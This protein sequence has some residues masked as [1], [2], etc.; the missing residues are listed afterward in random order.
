MKYA[1]TIYRFDENDDQVELVDRYITADQAIDL[2]MQANNLPD[3]DEELEVAETSPDD[4][5]ETDDVEAEQPKTK[6]TSNGAGGN[7]GTKP[8]RI[9]AAL[10][11]KIVADIEADELAPKEIAEKHGVNLQ[12]I[13]NLRSRNAR[14]E[15]NESDEPMQ[16]PKEP[17]LT[18]YAQQIRQPKAPEKTTEEKITDMVKEG[19]SLSELE[20][21][22]PSVPYIKLTEIYNQFKD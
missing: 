8:R 2:M 22:F 4:D 15:V 17:G 3:P 13:Y 14:P 18:R 1:I 16:E 7:D 19:L 6:I 11:A 9:D 5:K 12:S 21:A 20:M 10:K